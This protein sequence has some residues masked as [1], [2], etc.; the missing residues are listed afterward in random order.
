MLKPNMEAEKMKD[1]ILFVTKGGE[2][3]DDGFS[4]VLELAKTLNAG[5]EVLIIYP[6]RITNS[7]EDIMTAATFAEADDMQTIKKM[8][9]A[10]QNEFRAL[11]ERKI[12]T[13]V[14][15]SENT[16]VD[17]SCHRADG[18]LATTIKTFLKTRPYVDMVLLS[19]SLADDR[20]SF[21]IRKLLKNISKPIV[22]ISRPLASGI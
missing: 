18:D 22:N 1:K 17:L 8:I 14:S 6:S 2:Q 21:D 20:K 5:I 4:Y 16:E 19:P 15:Q 10:E 7:F 9:D 13:L 11:V 12:S 3:C